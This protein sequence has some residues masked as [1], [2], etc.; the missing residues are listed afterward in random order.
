MEARTATEG[1]ALPDWLA[2]LLQTSDALFPTG[3]YAHSLGLEEGVRLGMVKDEKSLLGYLQEHVAPGLIHLE[4]P[5]L[6]FACE[7]TVRAD[8][9]TVA[10][11]DAEI[12]AA[13][14]ARETREA[15]AQLGTRRLRALRIILPDSLPLAECDRLVA[16]GEMT[17]QQAIIGGVQA[18]VAGI[19]VAVALGAYFYQSLAATA[20]ASLKLIRIGQDAV[21]RVLRTASSRTPWAVARSLEVP[22]EEAGWFNPLLEIASMRHEHA[23]ER[24][25]IS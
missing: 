13:R 12:N 10:R 5:Y 14:L 15:G 23:G 2:L 8:W 4:M 18:A 21:Q 24:L 16:A 9:Q 7:A 11:L 25:F 3:A 6:R 22:R 19:P 17:G 1:E 20:G